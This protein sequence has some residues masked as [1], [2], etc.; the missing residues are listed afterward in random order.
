MD[1]K[2]KQG[3]TPLDIAMGE[4][5][6]VGV[7]SVAL[8]KAVEPVIPICLLLLASLPALAHHSAAAEYDSNKP[9]EIKGAVTEIEW[10]N[11]HVWIHLDVKDQNGQLTKWIFELGSPNLLKQN[12]WRKDSV[13]AGDS[14]VASGLAAKDADRTAKAKTVK[15]ADGK[16]LN[17][18]TPN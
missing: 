8:L 3:F 13:K 15:T 18:T 1:V 12:G 7:A 14:V 10:T 11:P 9:V 16:I 17:A 6:G 2:N 5:S 4:V